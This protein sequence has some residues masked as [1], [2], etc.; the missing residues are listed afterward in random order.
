MAK[1]QKEG[2]EALT[3]KLLEMVEEGKLTRRH[4]TGRNGQEREIFCIPKHNDS[5]DNDRLSKNTGK[6]GE[7]GI[8]ITATASIANTTSP[9]TTP[10]ACAKRNCTKSMMSGAKNTNEKSTTALEGKYTFV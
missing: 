4:K 7:L 2:T 1:Y 3:E 5:N 9:K 8:V 10:L 6:N